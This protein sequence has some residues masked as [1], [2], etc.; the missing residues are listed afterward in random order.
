[1][2][3]VCQASLANAR[4]L[5]STKE[6]VNNFLSSCKS[7]NLI[8]ENLKA[9]AMH[10]TIIRSIVALNSTRISKSILEFELIA[11]LLSID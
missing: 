7:W 5:I 11:F 4:S 10:T 9:L 6:N 2:N 3:V 1:M 8:E